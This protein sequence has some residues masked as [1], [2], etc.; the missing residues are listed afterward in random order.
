MKILAAL[1]NLIVCPGAGHVA[2]G[3]WRRGIPWLV[4]Q[5]ASAPLGLVHPVALMVAMLG[6][7]VGAAVEVSLLRAEP[8]GWLHG[9]LSFGGGVM[10]MVAFSMTS[11]AYVIEAFKIPSGAMIP[12]LEIGDHIFVSKLAVEPA[13][14]E[15]AVYINP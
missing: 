11:R 6:A 4:L 10:V 12:T 8:T 3:R 7:R 15:M 9:V 2:I 14:G 13:R 5:L 1:I